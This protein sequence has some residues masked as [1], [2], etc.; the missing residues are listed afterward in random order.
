MKRGLFDRTMEEN[1]AWLKSLTPKI[2]DETAVLKRETG[3]LGDNVKSLLSNK[4]L[5]EGHMVNSIDLLARAQESTSVNVVAI[6]STLDQLARTLPEGQQEA[7]ERIT[8]LQGDVAMVMIKA[9]EDRRL[10]EELNKNVKSMK[11]L[12]DN[13]A[14]DVSALR[15]ESTAT[16]GDLTAMRGDLSLIQRDTKEIVGITTYTMNG[17]MNIQATLTQMQSILVDRITGVDKKLTDLSEFL[18]VS[19]ILNFENFTQAIYS[20]LKCIYQFICYCYLILKAILSFVLE[21]QVVFTTLAA[22]SLS[23]RLPERFRRTTE[24]VILALLSSLQLYFLCILTNMFGAIFGIERIGSRTMESLYR[25]ILSCLSYLKELCVSYLT[26]PAITSSVKAYVTFIYLKIGT[27]FNFIVTTGREFMTTSVAPPVVTGAGGDTDIETVDD[28]Y[29][30]NEVGKNVRDLQ[31]E[32]LDMV[33]EL[34]TKRDIN[35]S[36]E[37]MKQIVFVMNNFMGLATNKKVGGVRLRTKKYKSV[38]MKKKVRKTR[39]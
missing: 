29:I 38:R 11:A 39:K 15:A 31:F 33:S 17:V 14:G 2:Q 37:E 12:L 28:D 21:V 10:L 35:I 27:I 36:K 3:P 30:L 7:I 4:A 26:D 20:L 23:S 9:E 24:N 1:A 22:T 8:G 25:T 18:R 6:K 32:F 13:V 16:R 5:L 34:Q 19:C